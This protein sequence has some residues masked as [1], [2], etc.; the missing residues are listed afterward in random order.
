MPGLKPVRT[1]RELFDLYASGNPMEVGVVLDSGLTVGRSWTENGSVKYAG[2]EGPATEAGGLDP[3]VYLGL[4]GP[5]R[6]AYLFGM[7]ANSKG[8]QVK[9]VLGAL[10]ATV[11]NIRL[12]ANTEAT[13]A[14]IGRVVEALAADATFAKD[15]REFLDSCLD[16]VKTAKLAADQT[17][18]RHRQTVQGVAQAAT[19]PAP[20]PGAEAKLAEIEDG[21]NLLRDRLAKVEAERDQCRRRWKELDAVRKAAPAPEAGTQERLAQ[22]NAELSMPLPDP[23]PEDQV[24]V[25]SKA[26]VKAEAVHRKANQEMVTAI[27]AESQAKLELDNAETLLRTV[28]EPDP[29]RVKALEAEVAGPAPE[30]VDAGA[31]AKLEEQLRIDTERHRATA[32]E[33]TRLMLERQKA[34]A[35]T[36]CPTCGR[37]VTDRE[38]ILRVLDQKIAQQ[39]EAEDFAE[40]NLVESTDQL[41]RC[42]SEMAS[43]GFKLNARAAAVEELATLENQSRSRKLAADAREKA[44]A[45]LGVAHDALASAQAVENVCTLDRTLAEEIFQRVNAKQ[46]ARAQAL[47]ARSDAEWELAHLTAR[48][49]DGE[50]ARVAA[51]KA[52]AEI[53]EVEAK[54]RTIG[55]QAAAITLKI[56]SQDRDRCL[57]VSAVRELIASRSEAAV[58]ARAVQAAEAA[59]AEAAV[60]KASVELVRQAQQ[61]V[62]ESAV[63]PLIETMNSFCRPL[64]QAEVKWVDGELSIG[65]RVSHRTASDSERML[66]Y[67]GLC[68][69]LAAGGGLRIATIGRFESFDPERATAL[70]GLVDELLHAGKIDQCI[71]VGVDTGHRIAWPDEADMAGIIT[72]K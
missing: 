15:A 34:S 70:V 50:N 37:E 36:H 52:E 35:Q 54:G 7:L 53:V 59:E 61:S 6:L 5:A 24:T 12:E 30:A 28:P 40:D 48:L 22:L 49:Q 3:D 42:R 27:L 68:L 1:G 2:Y 18:K 10:T 58:R 44:A 39:A 45:R 32:Q 57:A 66:L 65:G 67:A 25:A 71:L 17:A 51:A 62:V 41:N 47:E 29:V 20:D 23:V 69:A 13:E 4:S 63:G 38:A 19:G 16:T 8:L 46:Q 64:L 26:R 56:T 55:E 33:H 60:L 14:A 72:T 11:K 31:V 43:R 21:L 9:E